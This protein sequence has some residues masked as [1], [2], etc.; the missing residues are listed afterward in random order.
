[1]IATVR[2]HR[3]GVLDEEECALDVDVE[4]AVV[5]GLVDLCDWRELGDACVDEQDIDPP[6]LGRDPIDQNLGCGHVAS[7]GEQHLDPGERL[8]GSFHRVLAGAGNDHRCAFGLKEFG[9]LRTDAAG[10]SANES[11]LSVELGHEGFLIRME[12]LYL[13]DRK[14]PMT[15]AMVSSIFAKLYGVSNVLVDPKVRYSHKVYYGI[16]LY[17]NIP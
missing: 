11:N 16:F 13:R 10:A 7:V 8:P 6:V 9:G 5:K 14:G 12:L 17:T 2:N 4:L 3:D 15:W 1:M